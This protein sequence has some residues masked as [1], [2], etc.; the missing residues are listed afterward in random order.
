MLFINLVNSSIIILLKGPAVGVV[1]VGVPKGYIY[2]NILCLSYIGNILS[3]HSIV[4]QLK[5]ILNI[6]TIPCS[7]ILLC[8]LLVKGS[9]AVTLLVCCLEASTFIIGRGARYHV[10][11]VMVFISYSREC[12]DS[13][14]IVLWKHVSWRG[15]MQSFAQVSIVFRFIELLLPRHGVSSCCEWKS[16]HSDIENGYEYIEYAVT[17]IWQRGILQLGAWERG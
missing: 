1:H 7:I 5:T 6:V 8:L 15:A 11:F 14:L 9:I 12:Q 3:R 4:V 2:L 13:T 16:Q 10:K 17:Y